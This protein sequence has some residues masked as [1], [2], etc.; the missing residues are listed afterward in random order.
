MALATLET[1]KKN[2]ILRNI[3]LMFKAK[4]IELLDKHG[5]GF[6]YLASGFIAHYNLG[7]F[8]ANY[9][10]THA[11][12]EDILR[13][14][15]NN[16]WGNFSKSDRDY[17]YMMQ[18]KEI[19]NQICEFAKGY[20]ADIPEEKDCFKP[21]MVKSLFEEEQVWRK[22]IAKAY[23][24]HLRLG[25]YFNTTDPQRV[26]DLT[27]IT[28]AYNAKVVNGVGAGAMKDSEFLNMELTFDSGNLG[29]PSSLLDSYR[30]QI[31]TIFNHFSGRAFEMG[32]EDPLDESEDEE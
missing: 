20:L 26:V 18:K 30:D 14:Q 10:N 16:Q 9:G 5:Y 24:E 12:A 29:T 22:N 2:R 19:Y 28:M 4:N 8:I 1:G 21:P 6:L 25:N 32:F 15:P 11:L 17:E 3:G 27:D 7:G 31:W 23:S 13:N